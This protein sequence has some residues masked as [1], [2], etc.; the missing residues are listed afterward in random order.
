MLLVS[1]LVMLNMVQMRRVEPDFPLSHVLLR[2]DSQRVLSRFIFVVRNG[3]QML[4]APAVDGA[5]KTTYGRFIRWSLL[6]VF[7]RTLSAPL[8]SSDTN[9]GVMIDAMHLD[10]QLTAANLLK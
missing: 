6:T 4:D 2:V 7:D 5:H 10:A 9:D 3:I 1:D 8:A